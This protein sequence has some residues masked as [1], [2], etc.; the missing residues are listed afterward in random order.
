MR[1]LCDVLALISAHARDIN[2]DAGLRRRLAAQQTE[3]RVPE[4]KALGD[5]PLLRQETEGC[6]AY[7]SV[8]LHLASCADLGRSGSQGA[9]WPA[10]AA[11]AA[12]CQVR[13]GGGSVWGCSCGA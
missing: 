11:A 3:D 5:P 10:A 2:T 4:D 1:Q 7:L 12:E 9:A 6:H 8:L 13:R